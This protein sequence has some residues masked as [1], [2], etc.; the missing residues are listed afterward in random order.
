VTL[1]LS[2]AFLVSAVA[3]CFPH[4]IYPPLVY[5]LSRCRRPRV[6]GSAT[7]SATL[8]ISAFNEAAV[9]REKIENALALEFPCDRLEVMVISD[10]SEDGTDEIGLEYADRNVR[11]C[12][13]EPWQGKS[14]GLTRFYPQVHGDVLAFTDR[15]QRDGADGDR[16]RVI[17]N[18]CDTRMFSPAD[19]HAVR[20]R[21]GV[22]DASIVLV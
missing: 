19:K 21:L 17:P 16:I 12:R 7:P 9:I 11:L 3:L 8:V 22:E 10:A 4:L 6:P 14:A 20:Q 5:A 15:C 13:Q 2:I 1:A 18:G